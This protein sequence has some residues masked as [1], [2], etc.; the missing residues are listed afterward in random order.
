MMIYSFD[1]NVLIDVMNDRTGA[2]RKKFDELVRLRCELRI[3]SLVVHELFYGAL[4][5]RR[6]DTQIACTHHL[7]SQFEVAALDAEDVWVGTEMLVAL[8]KDGQSA[9]QIDGLIA[10]QAIRR[11][12]TVITRDI[13]FHEFRRVAGLKHETWPSLHEQRPA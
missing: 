7:L 9:G 6:P 13:G 4:I 1:S 8:R 2:S 10:G 5:S 12:W 3:C 11:G